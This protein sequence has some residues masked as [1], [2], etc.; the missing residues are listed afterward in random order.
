[1]ATHYF[2]ILKTTH[3]QLLNAHIPRL[4]WVEPTEIADTEEG[5][6][7]V[8]LEIENGFIKSINKASSQVQ[9]IPS[10]D[11]KKSI[12][13]P[14]FIDVHT[15]LDKG[16]I[17]QRSPNLE[18]TFKTAIE[19]VEADA[20]KYWK[21]EDIYQRMEFSL[22]CSYAHGTRAIRTHLDALGEQAKASYTVFETLKKQWCDRLFLQAVA[23]VPLAHFLTKEGVKLADKVADTE[24]ILGGFAVMNPQLNLQLDHLFSLAKERQLSLD[25]HVDENGDPTSMCLQKVAETALKYDFNQPILCG[26]CC[27]LAVQDEEQA[28]KTI[29]LVKEANIDIVSLPMCNLYLQDRKPV[30]FTPFWRGVTRV[31]ELK[32]AGISVAFASDNCRDP[33]YA[34]G[35]HDGLEVFSQAVK[36]AHLDIN[37]DDWIKS[38]TQTPA[39]IMG[40]PHLGMIKVG[41][42][43]DLII[44]RARY[45]SELLSRNQSDRLVLSQGKMIDTTLPD[46]EE[47]DH[48]C[49]S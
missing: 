37:Y 28:S 15:H 2:Q 12:I 44:F 27:S 39:Q 23:L 45:Y 40:L 9:N 33:F 14:K 30:G 36:I 29:Q 32:K 38:V 20:Q 8:N 43:A 7:L 47:L 10:I 35:D 6:C 11:L 22:K 41:M 46:Y 16:H 42:P 31:Q 13:L 18:G 48:I 5:F 49:L 26:H 24:G 4:L 17:W 3:Y 1:M 21:A 34:F 19:T 25:L